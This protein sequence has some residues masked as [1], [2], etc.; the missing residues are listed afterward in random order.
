MEQ[1]ELDDMCPSCKSHNVEGDEPSYGN[2]TIEIPFTCNEC[3]TTWN[4]QYGW[5]QN[6]DIETEEDFDK[7]LSNSTLVESTKIKAYKGT[8]LIDM[9][10]NT[11]KPK[12]KLQ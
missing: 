8:E 9:V 7:R 11:Y 6:T 2:H 10:M 5:Y 3:E 4:A 12:D 1:T